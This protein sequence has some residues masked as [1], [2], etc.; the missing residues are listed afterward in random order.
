MCIVF[1]A[2]LLAICLGTPEGARLSQRLVRLVALFE[3]S[4]NRYQMFRRSVQM[5]E[6][7]YK[8]EVISAK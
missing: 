2:T 3:E 7:Q 5:W 6:V 4:S 8:N 1:G